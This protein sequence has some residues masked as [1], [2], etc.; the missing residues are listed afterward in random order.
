MGRI[1]PTVALTGLLCGQS[2][3]VSPQKCATR[4]DNKWQ[5]KKKNWHLLIFSQ[6]KLVIRTPNEVLRL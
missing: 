4:K 3:H 6:S 5:I 1:G 2:R